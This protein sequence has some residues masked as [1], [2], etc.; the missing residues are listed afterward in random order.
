MGQTVSLSVLDGM[1]VIYVDRVRNH[2]P[3]GVVL[4]LGS[5]IPA[6]CA[7]LGKAILA[8]LPP[9]ELDARLDKSDLS[10]CTPNSIIDRAALK[11]DLASVR[12]LGYSVNDQEWVLGLRSTG[13][14]ILGDDGGAVASVNIAVSAMQFS[15]EELEAQLSPA[16][17]DTARNISY[18]MGFAP[19]L[20]TN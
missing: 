12:A 1:H 13:A 2:E 10:P 15:R 18:A 3:V 17:R 11:D 14:P 9:D 8:F 5:R 4:G 7:S 16:V 19:A 6:Q 20:V